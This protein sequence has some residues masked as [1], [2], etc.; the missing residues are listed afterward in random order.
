MAKNIS[1]KDVTSE[2]DP[3]CFDTRQQAYGFTNR[4][5]LIPCCWCDTQYNRRDKDYQKLLMVSKLEDHDS[6][7][8]IVTQEEWVE[9]YENLKQNKGFWV[10]HHVCKKRETPQHKKE[11]RISPNGETRVKST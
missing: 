11:T 6:I 8:E 9:F 2:L 1:I 4:G 10:C 7:E 3:K 5:E